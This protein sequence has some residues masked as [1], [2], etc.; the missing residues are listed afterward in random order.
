[1]LT[2]CTYLANCVSVIRDTTTFFKMDDVNDCHMLGR[3]G[4]NEK[5]KDNELFKIKLVLSSLANTIVLCPMVADLYTKSSTDNE[6]WT[7]YKS[8]VPGIILNSD[9]DRVVISVQLCLADRDSGFATWRETLLNTSD[10]KATQNNFHTFKMTS[11]KNCMAGLKFP[12]H[13][14]ANIFLREILGNISNLPDGSNFSN[15]PLRESNVTKKKICKAEI[16][17]PCMFTHVAGFTSEPNRDSVSR[18]PLCH[19]DANSEPRS[20]KDMTSQWYDIEDNG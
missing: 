9:I 20:T 2:Y 16:S 12:H 1:M 8:G 4:D 5:V 17:T 15:V 3:S 10:Y 19:P 18:L 11:Q 7:Y 14:G 13:E 6:T